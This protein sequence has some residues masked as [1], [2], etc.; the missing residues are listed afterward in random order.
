MKTIVVA[1]DYPGVRQLVRDT[2]EPRGYQVF[3]AVN[4]IQALQLVQLEHPSLVILDRRM[5]GLTGDQVCAEL[6]TDPTTRTLPV[7]IMTADTGDDV[8]GYMLAAGA[9]AFFEKPFSPKELLTA[10]R[11]LVGE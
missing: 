6:R 2:L 9:N 1:D 11:Q 7:V 10:V 4:G 3:E 8:Q 5:P